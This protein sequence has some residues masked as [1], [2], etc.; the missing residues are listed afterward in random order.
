MMCVIDCRNKQSLRALT[1]AAEKI[2]Q[3]DY[4]GI[5]K[6]LPVHIL[7]YYELRDKES[8]KILEA[9]TLVIEIGLEEKEAEQIVDD[10]NLEYEKSNKENLFDSLLRT[11]KC[12]FSKYGINEPVV[13]ED[14]DCGMVYFY[15]LQ[16]K[17]RCK[18]QTVSIESNGTEEGNDRI[19]VDDEQMHRF[20]G[21]IPTISVEEGR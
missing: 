2:N 20:V 19:P 7:G 4:V 9:P 1:S 10:N 5:N 3:S 6:E 11:L 12:K 13:E 17:E 8:Q 16:D 15:S 18:I 14:T 21:P